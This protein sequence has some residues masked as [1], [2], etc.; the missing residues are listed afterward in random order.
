MFG[1]WPEDK[2]YWTG[3]EFDKALDRYGFNGDV[4]PWV[5]ALQSLK[6]GQ[7]VD[8]NK[9]VAKAVYTIQHAPENGMSD[10]DKADLFN[11]TTDQIATSRANAER[12]AI[13]KQALGGGEGEADAAQE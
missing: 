1:K 2:L 5:E 11:K 6:D 13:I 3:S 9:M 4:D 12:Q 7:D 8:V 10:A